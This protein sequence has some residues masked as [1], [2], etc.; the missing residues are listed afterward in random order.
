[1]YVFLS[2]CVC[3]CAFINMFSTLFYCNHLNPN[4]LHLGLVKDAVHAMGQL[5]LQIGILWMCFGFLKLQFGK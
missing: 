5:L 3:T 1:M 4:N 2:V